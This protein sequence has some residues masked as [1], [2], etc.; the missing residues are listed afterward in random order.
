MRDELA[1]ILRASETTVLLVTHDQEE[2]L[3]LA[4]RVALMR[5]GRIVQVEAPE[6]L[7]FHPVDRWTAEFVGGANFVPGRREGERLATPLGPVG[8]DPA[9]EG[10]CEVLVRPELVQ[11]EPSDAG[12]GVVVAREFRGHDVF[13]RVLLDDGTRVASHRPSNELVALGDRVRLR[14]H[15][16]PITV[17]P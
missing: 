9:A 11:L 13:Y 16:G 8:A 15:D 4:D 10:D 12:P 14:L 17:F 6:R 7:Y 1:A 3:A 2:A 5:D